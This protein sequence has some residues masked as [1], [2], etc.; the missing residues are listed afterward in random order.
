MV[1]Y[2]RC[3]VKASTPAYTMRYNR[4]EE[5]FEERWTKSKDIYVKV[6]LLLKLK[7]TQVRDA[8]EHVMAAACETTMYRG[9]FNLASMIGLKVKVRP[10]K[11][12]RTGVHPQTKKPVVFKARRAIR[13]VRV[14]PLPRLHCYVRPV[15]EDAD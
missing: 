10:A 6:G 5:A 7:W 3:P 1:Y 9:S 2:K 12:A 8:F 14:R 13:M 15:V 11:E 4:K